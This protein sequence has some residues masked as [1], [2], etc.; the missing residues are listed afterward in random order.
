MAYMKQNELERLDHNERLYELVEVYMTNAKMDEFIVE[1][2]L[3]TMTLKEAIDIILEDAL[4]DL[5]FTPEET[6]EFLTLVK[7]YKEE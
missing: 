4:Y 7:E 1:L 6:Q 2:E 5:N 3:L